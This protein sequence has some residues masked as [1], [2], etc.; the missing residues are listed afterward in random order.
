MAAVFRGLLPVVPLH[1]LDRG[2]GAI[3]VEAV[4]PLDDVRGFVLQIEAAPGRRPDH[5]GAAQ[6]LSRFRPRRAAI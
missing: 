2:D 5:Q 6:L 1:D 4:D 3:A